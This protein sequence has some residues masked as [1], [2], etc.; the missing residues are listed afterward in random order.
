MTRI[1][2]AVCAC[3][4]SSLSF[5]EEFLG[6]VNSPHKVA[7]L[8]YGRQALL[9]RINMIRE[10]K[11]SI[12]I[13]TFIWTNDA[14]GRLIAREL[15]VAAERGV[16]VRI[17]ADQMFS[18][19]DPANI[20]YLATAHPNLTLK[21]Y[22]PVANHIKASTLAIISS[23]ITDFKSMNQR[24]HNKLMVVDNKEAIT[25][26]R[27][28]ENTY[29]DYAKGL[30]FKDR[31][32]Y[33][34]GEV[35]RD[36]TLSFNRFWESKLAVLSTDL[37]DVARVVKNGKVKETAANS[38]QGELLRSLDVAL[39]GDEFSKKFK[40]L[41]CNVNKVAFVSDS[42]GKNASWLLDGGGDM[43]VKAAKLVAATQKTLLIQSPYL[44]LCDD[45]ME[46]FGELSKKGVDLT[47][48]TNSLAATDSWP[49]YGLFYK[50]KKKLIKDIKMN[51]FEYKPLPKT[52]KQLF[53]GYDGIREEM[54]NIQ[55]ND[56]LEKIPYLCLHAKSM[57]IDKKIAF[58]G[59]YNLDPRSANLNTEVALLVWDEAFATK[60]HESISAD[61]VAGNSWT[62]WK[63]DRGAASRAFY[64][65]LNFINTPIEKYTPVDIVPKTY[66]SCFEL[67]DGKAEVKTTDPLFYKNYKD[68]GSFPMVPVTEGKQIRARLFK[69]FGSMT[70]PIL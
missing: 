54:G 51:I 29:F 55:S 26:G 50:Q 12:S 38:R 28:I 65:V 33:V 8:D 61:T 10:A 32:V 16:K 64:G 5:A 27:N 41:L 22:N 13:Q 57:V 46:L 14:A 40:S 4:A 3:V 44:V 20:A 69:A 1:A 11:E 49:T 15:I 63:R 53:Y 36:M 58:I 66:T 68:V 42:P 24:M 9:V 35:V 17:L 43:T 30:N 39:E 19:N 18:E 31:E 60:L 6:T 48:S 59:S 34:S 2:L 25:G 62:V 70:R 52:M 56:D 7:M 21:H 23:G 47:V 37:R 67:I 45:A